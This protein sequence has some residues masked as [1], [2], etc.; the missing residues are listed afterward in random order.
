MTNSGRPRGRIAALARHP[1]VR[2]AVILLVL[3]LAVPVLWVLNLERGLEAEYAAIR[4][5]GLP[6]TLGELDA[7]YDAPPAAENAADV[8]AQAF[9]QQ[10]LPD[11]KESGLLPLVG[12]AGLPA[13][14]AAFDDAMK[15]AIAEHVALNAACLD[16][17]HKAAGMPRCR[18]PADLSQWPL[19]P[20]EHWARA[21]SAT[22]LLTLQAIHLTEAGDADGAAGALAAALAISRSLGQEPLVISQIVGA[23]CWDT[24]CY[25]IE[26]TL[27]RGGQTEASLARLSDALVAQEENAQFWRGYVGERCSVIHGMEHVQAVEASDA[28]EWSDLFDMA[29][30]WRRDM[31][32]FLRDMDA[33]IEAAQQPPWQAYA[34]VREECAALGA[35]SP[36]I[37]RV[38]L[39]S[40]ARAMTAHTRGVAQR[41]MAQVAVAAERY[42]L[43]TGGLPDALEELVPEYLPSVPIDPFDGNPIRYRKTETGYVVYSIA[44]D[45]VDGGGAETEDDGEFGDLAFAVAR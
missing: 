26:W 21:P 45:E 37:F 42:R 39:P 20:Q 35:Q 15:Q 4:E 7:W 36:T 22:R 25:G 5:K 16:L 30:L 6:V 28:F 32:R 34:G 23:A 17:L 38:M 1:A 19:P 29:G 3:C 44:L 13:P 24:T 18:Y 14:S 41:C 11:D 43:A 8:F 2:V 10:V 9:E 40:F 12:G 27:K 33:L 31:L